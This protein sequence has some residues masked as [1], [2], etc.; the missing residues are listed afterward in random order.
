MACC[1]DARR[2]N[3]IEEA[4]SII[5]DTIMQHGQRKLAQPRSRVLRIAERGLI[6][7]GADF[8]P[9][10]A[11]SIPAHTAP[12]E[13]QRTCVL[14]FGV[15]DVLP[16]PAAADKPHTAMKTSGLVAVLAGASAV[17]AFVPSPSASLGLRS[18]TSCVS[19]APVGRQSRVQQHYMV[20]A[21][22]KEEGT[23]AAVPHGGALINLN[24]KTDEEKKVRSA[25]MYLECLRA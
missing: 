13:A 9:P 25:C 5:D 11:S 15:F 6:A 10:P 24:L 16:L 19:K 23:V 21:P 3:T 4:A 14:F 7:E 12:P 8:L 18:R 2:S 1:S 22:A 20:A 17:E